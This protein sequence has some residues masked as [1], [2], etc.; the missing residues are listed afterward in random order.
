MS[1]CVAA[2]SVW[3]CVCGYDYVCVLT[4]YLIVL[5]INDNSANNTDKQ[6]ANMS[7]NTESANVTTMKTHLAKEADEKQT[8]S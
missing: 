3:L 7:A 1:G 2:G 5:L 4:H 8:A 6:M